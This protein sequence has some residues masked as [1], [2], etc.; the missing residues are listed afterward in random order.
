MPKANSKIWLLITFLFAAG[1]V[2]LTFPKVFT[3]HGHIIPGMGGDSGKNVFAYLYH[4]FYDKGFWFTG[5]NYPY[6]EQI[7]YTDGQPLLSVSLSYLAYITPGQ[8]LSVMWSLIMTSYVI[9]IVYVYKT[10]VHFSVRPLIAMLF[11]S[12]II[13]LSPQL[14]RTLGHFGLSYACVVPML[15]YWTLKYD[16]QPKW[17]YPVY[18]LILGLLANFLHPY[19]SAVILVWVGFYAVGYFIFNHSPVRQKLKH[20]APLF[21]SIAVLFTTIGIV[22]KVTDPITDRPIT[23]YGLTAYCAHGDHIFTSYYSPVWRLIEGDS[24]KLRESSGQEGFT[25]LGLAVLA[26]VI[27]SIIKFVIDRKRKLPVTAAGQVYSFPPVMLFVAFASLL[28]A[29]G[30][31]FVWHM[32]WIVNY[33][34]FLRQFRTLGR[35][36][37]IFYYIIT[38]YG[39]VVI[40]RSYAGLLLKGKTTSAYSLLLAAL[41]IWGIEASGYIKSEHSSLADS[42]NNYDQV[43]GPK[44][45]DWPQFLAQHHYSPSDFQAILLLRY[46]HVGSDKLWLGRDMS[47]NEIATGLIS[48]LQLHLPMIDAM[49]ARSSW[50]ITEKQVKIAGGPFAQKPMLNELPNEKAFLLLNLN[51]DELDDDQGY[52]L[53]SSDLIGTFGDAHVYA[54]YPARIQ[55]MDKHY[56]DSVRAMLP[57]LKVGDTCIACTGSWYINHFDSIPIRPPFFS[58]G[59]QPQI[60]DFET[61]ITTIP[62]KPASDNQPYEFSCWFLLGDEN[63]RSPFFKL[64]LLDDKGNTIRTEDVLTKESTDNRGLWFRSLLFFTIPSKC[65]AIRCRLRNE[66]D[67]TYKVMDEMQLRP[68]GALI[69]SKSAEGSV[70]VNNHLLLK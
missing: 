42:A 19:F 53:K 29:M 22:M 7:V 56:T 17:K 5:M 12:L 43:Y 30:V 15:F 25:Y 61:V 38:V 27:F 21:I 1:I 66:P 6:G 3:A 18:I 9:A 68:I 70:M 58:K 47:Q 37:W 41:C 39:A 52:L 49:M 45:Q 62:V 40:Y 59:A 69:I 48:C 63:Y 32:E 64:D 13:I 14:Y 2:V 46:F 31:P 10:L 67:N 11:A 20:L 28:F 57:Y 44:R 55:A 8:A 24:E 36:T 33:L 50:S 26:A 4:I 16:A 23:P 34:S 54:C 60:K 65:T 51:G 35:F